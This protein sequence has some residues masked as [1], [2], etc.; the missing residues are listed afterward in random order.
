MPTA[1]K[2]YT[3]G[4]ELS[5]DP[6]LPKLTGKEIRFLLVNL[7]KLIMINDQPE[8]FNKLLEIKYKRQSFDDLFDK[9]CA[10]LPFLEERI[11]NERI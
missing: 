8:E 9:I 6:D 5:N 2:V 4:I 7:T 3:L 11:K 10:Q 1:D